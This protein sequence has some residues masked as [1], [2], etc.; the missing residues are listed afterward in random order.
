MATVSELL[1]K[2][3][4]MEASR[5]SYESHW[6]E[7][8]DRM[9]PRQAEFFGQRTP[10]GKR[11]EKIYDSTAQRALP[12]FA[13]VMESN[14]TPRQSIW[15]RLKLKGLAEQGGPAGEYFDLLNQTL[16]EARY[17]SRT[18]FASTAHEAYMSLGAFGTAAIFIDKSDISP[19][20]YT[21]CHL[22]EIYILEN[23]WGRIDTVHRKFRMTARQVL[24]KF[25]AARI[26][27]QVHKLASTR[28]EAW[29]TVLHCTSPNTNRVMGR[30]D[31]AG[32]PW[33]CQYVLPEF[34]TIVLEGGYKSWPW[35]ISRYVKAPREEYGRSPGMDALADMKTLNEARKASIKGWHQASAPGWMVHAD[36]MLSKFNARP[37]AINVGFVSDDGRPLA[38]P[39][40]SGARLDI[41]VAMTDQ[42]TSNINDVFLV[43]AFLMGLQTPNMT[44]TEVIERAKQQ[45]IMLMPTAGRQQS[46]FLGPCIEREL[47]L[48]ADARALPLPPPEVIE[49]FQNTGGIY[50]VEYVSPLS[51]AARAEESLSVVRLLERVI[52]MAQIDPSVMDN[53]DLDAAVRILHR[54]GGAANELLRDAKEIDAIREQRAQQ[55]AMQ[56]AMQ[57]GPALGQTVAGLSRAA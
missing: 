13:S 47:E 1:A 56:A 46:E 5:A 4:G 51:S 32:M 19:V 50:E 35:A 2:Q 45:G 9:L 17:S 7:I 57:A 39:M 25:D 43:N 42:F 33:A 12:K 44:A 24:Q 16:F 15:H 49:L 27:E 40:N 36:G 31:A 28:P 21:L 18:S 37:D 11:S 14:L 3:N 20:H 29:V 26:P 55:Q 6:Q 53:I 48:L 30:E 34:Q 54:S 10:G 22:A 23:A 41:D 52:P 8:A 38:L